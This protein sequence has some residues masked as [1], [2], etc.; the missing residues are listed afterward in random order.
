MTFGCWRDLFYWFYWFVRLSNRNLGCKFLLLLI[1][2]QLI[3]FIFGEVLGYQKINFKG[4]SIN[5]IDFGDRLFCSNQSSKYQ[6]DLIKGYM[7]YSWSSKWHV[8]LTFDYS[9]DVEE[10]EWILWREWIEVACNWTYFHYSWDVWNLLSEQLVA[11]IYRCDMIE[12]MI[13]FHM[14]YFLLF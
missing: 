5:F 1:V 10:I 2:H 7:P 4:L 14:S 8:P 13:V 3:K 11:E 6:T 9:K 12:M